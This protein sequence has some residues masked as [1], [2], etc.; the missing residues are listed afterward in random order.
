LSQPSATQKGVSKTLTTRA[1]AQVAGIDKAV[2][3]HRLSGTW[4]P[5][6]ENYE[7]FIAAEEDQET[8]TAQPYPF[9]LAHALEGA[10]E[11]L[12]DRDDWQIE[13]KWDGIRAQAIHR[14][15]EAL[16]WSRGEELITERFPD[17]LDAI[18]MLPQGTVLDGEILIWGDDAPQSFA[19]LQRRI[20]RKKVGAKLLAELP[21]TFMAYDLLESED[22]DI[23]DLPTEERRRLLEETINRVG[24]GIPLR[25]SPLV[26]ESTWDELVAKREE[27]RARLVEGFM[28]KRKASPYQ[29]GRVKGDWWKWKVDP[30]SCDCVMIYAQ[31][32]HGRRAS[33]YT[34]YTFGVWDGDELVPVMKAYSGLTDK[35]IT[36]VDRWIRQH[37]V[38]R[39]GPVR[40]I[41]PHHV[42]EL[43]FEGIQRS[44][45]HKSGVAV[46]FPRIHRW[47]EDKTPKD[48]DR[49][50]T[51]MNLIDEVTA[52]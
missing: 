22:R 39:F 27:S 26:E 7:R 25:L 9:C 1:L 8:S 32:G 5:T 33:L 29:V 36:K 23:R 50:E 51:L 17:L 20:G 31:R 18:R 52:P 13:W 28:L 4:E 11:D 10:P 48:A 19:Q 45:R 41:E 24:S 2:M 43:H 15:N 46:R 6:A 40:V 14:G 16:I 35:E 38:D 21:A 42:F 34:D 44:T 3:A 37:T 47:R 49:L 30:F 12:G